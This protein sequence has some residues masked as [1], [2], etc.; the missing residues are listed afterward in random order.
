MLRTWREDKN[1]ASQKF[2]VTPDYKLVDKFRIRAGF[3]L[4]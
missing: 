1:F 2:R 4:S 3:G